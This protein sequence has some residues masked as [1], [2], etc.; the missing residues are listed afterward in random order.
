MPIKVEDV[1]DVPDD[2]YHPAPQSA[3][4]YRSY[5]QSE[6]G[7]CR[8]C[9]TAWFKNWRW[10]HYQANTDTVFCHTCCKALKTKKVD[11]TKGN[12]E[13]SFIVNGFSNWKDSMR[14]FKKHDASDVYKHAIEKL[15]IL[16]RTTRDIGESL[17]AA[18]E[19]EK[20]MNHEYLL[21][22]LHNIPC[23]LAQQG[24]VLCG[25]GNEADSYFIQLLRL[26]ANDDSRILDYSNEHG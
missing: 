12:W 16:P 9:R 4:P 13:A 1:F 20:W 24:I 7:T 18:H 15:H 10:L 14:I 17:N 21:K 6:K 25:D 26:R 19:K 22:V 3:L 2:P 23:F 8:C 11:L 5:S